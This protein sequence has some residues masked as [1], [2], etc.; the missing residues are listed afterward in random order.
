MEDMATGEIRLSILWEWVHKGASLTLADPSVGVSEGETFTLAL[1]Q[2]LIAE[3]YD[4]LQHADTRD[5]HADS[6]GTTLPIAREI[7]E[8]YVSEPVKAPWYV[9]LLN[10]TLGVTDAAA[11]R[12]RIA[13]YMDAFAADGTRITQNLDFA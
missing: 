12:A 13:R 10:I 9:D 4:K 3:E 7:V 8:H 2:R 1:C 5:V 6:K 11:A